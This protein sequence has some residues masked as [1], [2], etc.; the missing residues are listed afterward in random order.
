MAGALPCTKKRDPLLRN[1]SELEG[2]CPEGLAVELPY[3]VWMLIYA[4]SD[5]REIHS[6]FLKLLF[7]ASVSSSQPVLYLTHTI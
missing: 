4:L 7:K 5:E 3:Q 2:T 6:I 1:G